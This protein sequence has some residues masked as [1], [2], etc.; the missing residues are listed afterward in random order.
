MSTATKKAPEAGV[1]ERAWGGI[2][3]WV[4][5]HRN[6]LP[7]LAALLI[8]IGM[9]IYGEVAYGRILQASTISNLLINNSHLI[10]MAVALTF[11]IVTGGIDLSV[12]A[13]IAFSSVAG[14]MLAEAGWNA[15]LVIALMILF[16]ATFGLISGVLIQYFDV[17]PFIATLAMMFLARGL[18][19]TLSTVPERL[20]DDSPIKLIGKQ[21][22]IYDG[23]KVNDLVITPGVIIAI[24]VVLFGVFMLH[25]T[26][27]GR[28]V[29]AI[30][31][32]EQSATLM[33]LPVHQTKMWVYVISGA[34]AGV[35]AVVYTSRIGTAQNIVGIGWELDAIAATVIGGTLL[36]G[37]AG[38]VLGSVVG[39]LTLGL[40]IVLIARDGAVPA[41]ATTI[42]TGGTLLVFVLLQRAVVWKRE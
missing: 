12:G 1:P 39:A 35:A 19:S 17:Q 29:Y 18:A 5:T 13:V 30:G 15:Y 32:K 3:G 21:L 28:T 11:V 38:F 41:G 36:T 7:T 33:G 26:R 2:V 14:V 20:A 4:K 9:V 6:L 27:L 31:G 34:L 40:M 10:I 23:P 24:V 37:G 25:R 42:I 22:K 16:G 8:F